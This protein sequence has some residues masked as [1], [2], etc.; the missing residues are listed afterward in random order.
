M[1]FPHQVIPRKIHLTQRVDF[2]PQIGHRSE[3]LAMSFERESGALAVLDAANQVLI[4]SLDAAEVMLIAALPPGKYRDLTWKVG[5]RDQRELAILQLGPVGEELWWSRA[6]R[7]G[8]RWKPAAFEELDFGWAGRNR[9]WRREGQWVL[10]GGG[11]LEQDYTFLCVDPLKRYLLGARGN[12]VLVLDSKGEKE[13]DTLEHPGGDILGLALDERGEWAY[14]L[15]ESGIVKRYEPLRPVR[16]FTFQAAAD[17][18]CLAVDFAKKIVAVGDS[19]GHIN[20]FDAQTGRRLLRTRKQLPTFVGELHLTESVGFFGYRRDSFGAYLDEEAVILPQHP[21]P[22]AVQ[23]SAPGLQFPWVG[24]A[25]QDGRTAFVNLQTEDIQEGP[26]APWPLACFAVGEYLVAGAKAAGIWWNDGIEERELALDDDAEPV[27]LAVANDG[28]IAAI[29][30]PEKVVLFS[31]KKASPLRTIEIPK[32]CSLAFS[33]WRKKTVLYGVDF[34][35]VLWRFDLGR[36]APRRIGVVE[37]D[38]HPSFLSFIHLV[39]DGD[40]TLRGLV[41]A[42]NAHRWLLMIDRSNAQATLLT[43]LVVVGNQVVLSYDEDGTRLRQDLEHS[44]RF[45]SGL[46]A[47]EPREWLRD[48]GLSPS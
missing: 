15:D 34:N 22:S 44:L 21:F 37:V 41:T 43:G 33:T 4:W 8:E 24:L 10:P 7:G 9:A 20:A 32:L 36:G 39:A 6:A 12:E 29:A 42:D 13:L 5:A 19:E 11:I 38:N 26:R 31:I 27:A 3:I 47:Y 16:Q 48:P 23:T 17:S 30:Y 35:S 45:V 46:R 14:S 18:R 28:A 25:Y 2:V 40:G 1:S